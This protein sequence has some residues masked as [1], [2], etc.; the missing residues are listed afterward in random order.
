MI[1]KIAL[2]TSKNDI[3]PTNSD[4]NL[5]EIHLL[6]SNFPSKIISKD[7][8]PAFIGGYYDKKYRK[9]ENLIARTLI[10]LDID[11][12]NGSKNDLNTLLNNIL[13]FYRYSY[14]STSNHLKTNPRIRLVLYPQNEIKIIDYKNIVINLVNKFSLNKHFDIDL[15]SSTT[16]NQLMYLPHR[17]HEDYVPWS[18]NNVGELIELNCSSTEITIK[19]NENKIS[20]SEQK[21]LEILKNYPVEDLEYN[22]W[23]NVGFALHHNYEAKERGATIWY[24]WSSK[25]SRPQYE[26]KKK[27]KDDIF[28]RYKKF[29]KNN[30]N[31]ITFATI[32][33]AAKEKNYFTN[34]D[35]IQEKLD[36]LTE[37]SNQKEISEI[38]ELVSKQD[39]I[40]QE[41][42]LK[43]IKNKTKIS[44]K[45]LQRKLRTLSEE[46]IPITCW[47][48]VKGEN[49]TPVFSDENFKILLDFYKIKLKFDII[50]KTQVITINE[51]KEKD[52]NSAY[53][54][55]ENLCSKN[56]LPVG[57]QLR[58]TITR[59]CAENSFNSFKDWVESKSWD[60]KDRFEKFLTSVVVEDIYEEIKVL[61][62]EKWLLLL[63]HV[64]CLNDNHEAKMARL[65]LIFQSVK[66]FIGK[67][68]WC[69]NL[70]PNH[71]SDDYIAA[72][73]SLNVNDS[74]S[75]KKAI[76]KVIAELG[77]ITSTFKKS[78]IDEMKNFLSNT[79]D[80]LN[81]KYLADHKVYR[82]RTVFFG[83]TNETEFLRDKTGST[84]F[85]VI[86]VISC[87]KS[88][89]DMQQLYAQLL[90][91]AK[92]N[93]NY[94]LTE[95]EL[96]KQAFFNAQF[97]NEDPMEILF[98]KYFKT[99]DDNRKL[100]LNS[101]QVLLEM[102]YKE[103]EP[104][105]KVKAN[106]IASILRKKG[107]SRS[108]KDKKWYL[109]PLREIIY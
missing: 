19:N 4:Y 106:E 79:S 15:T 5:E 93:P 96:E 34:I 63:L 94:L 65:A 40:D 82:R 18:G 107:Y 28:S 102:G 73:Q 57:I 51:I 33:K 80:I 87:N 64:T 81:I 61:Y 72:G 25:D 26:D 109:P 1:V 41:I 48:D 46:C 11:C 17:S 90:E 32:A 78:D 67:T 7:N 74:M 84:R 100:K 55:I 91:K 44:I 77:E 29:G 22:S 101:T 24:K 36:N 38:L 98:D 9:T 35:D 50:L 68:T 71:M 75:V 52:I 54:I 14:Y 97:E 30:K 105:L 66:Q 47:I 45:V 95:E 70:V 60:G 92:V 23:L 62:I 49:R 20:Y 12:Y 108:H 103:H 59:F 16:A 6:F 83:S 76:S 13:G 42:S 31:P 21:I 3:K 104:K 99:E 2:F 58:N 8:S 10:T 85:L 89:I 88:D 86:P 69:K 56:M 27:I 43:I 53:S 39:I 37:N